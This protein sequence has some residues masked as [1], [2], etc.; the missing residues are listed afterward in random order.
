[1]TNEEKIESMLKFY[2]GSR[3]LKDLLLEMAEWKEQQVIEKTINFFNNNSHVNFG[4][5]DDLEIDKFEDEY[6]KYMKG[7]TEIVKKKK[8]EIVPTKLDVFNEMQFDIDLPAFLK[9]VI[10][11]SG[12]RLYAPT[13]NILKI[14]LLNLAQ[15]ATELN[16][17]ILNVLMLRM[18]FYE[19][20]AQ[21][22]HKII[23]KIKEE[24]EKEKNN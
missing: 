16:D 23:E 14:H 12:Q 1:M 3:T 9:E 5:I 8:Q 2:H 11:N 24:I 13:W 18:N 21:D 10:E 4:W 20:P 15:R 19:V 7:E 6:V 17:P 22:R